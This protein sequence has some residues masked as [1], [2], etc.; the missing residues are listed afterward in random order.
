M[1]LRN[2]LM[3]DRTETDSTN[4]G[5]YMQQTLQ[6][7]RHYVTSYYQSR[8]QQDLFQEVKSFC[9]FIGHARSGHSIIGALLDAHP[10]I[11][12][13]DEVDILRYIA[14]GFGKKQIYHILL[15]RSQRQ[16]ANGRTKQG[17]EQQRYSY[18]VPDQWQGQYE[19]LRVIG[20]SK[21]GRTTQRLA[22]DPTL[23]NKLQGAVGQANVKLIN[24]I[25]NPYD[26]ISTLMLRGGRSFENAINNYFLNC[27][28]L[29]DLEKQ[30]DDANW[31]LVR[32]EEFITHPQLELT[33]I[34][35]FLGVTPADDYLEACANILYSSPAKSRYKVP[36]TTP[37]IEE[38]AQ[39]IAQ[40][41]FLN[42]YSY[43]A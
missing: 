26:N 23:L 39:Q 15:T 34:C 4:L 5:T 25:R 7:T 14:A 24:V 19:Q 22:Q 32:Q 28:T 18:F 9:L 27:H 33:Q 30:A 36:W 1:S 12:L 42:G 43:E 31:L 21:A 2:M 6:L 20:S 35:H 17:R 3:A 13:P 16:A 29:A 38:V 40:F 41:D 10:Q 8:N 37:L 11:I